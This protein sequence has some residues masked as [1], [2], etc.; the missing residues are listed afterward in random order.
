MTITISPDLKDAAV[1]ASERA[2]KTFAG[3]FIVGAGLLG[4]AVDAVTGQVTVAA[5]Q[6]SW[7][8]GLDV[9]AGTTVVS[10]L[11]SLASIKLGNPGTASLT[12][13]VIGMFKARQPA[14]QSVNVEFGG[15]G[16]GG[17]GV[18]AAAEAVQAQNALRAQS[19]IARPGG[20]L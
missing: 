7:A 5:S 14:A 12:K 10:L 18:T 8:H 15:T 1:D 2:V 20:T 16:G 9:G 6:I 13:A 19:Q 4:A 3:G 17:S 11:F